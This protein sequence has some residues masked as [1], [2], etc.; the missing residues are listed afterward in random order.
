MAHALAACPHPNTVAESLRMT[1]S[2]CDSGCQSASS[3]QQ[4]R[5]MSTASHDPCTTSAPLTHPTI[6]T[7]T[8]LH[9]AVLTHVATLEYRDS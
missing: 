7:P 9:A 8:Q 3:T 2:A 1:F 4:S 6:M 5:L